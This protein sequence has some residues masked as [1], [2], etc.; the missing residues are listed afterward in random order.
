M[1][2]GL[3]LVDN[4]FYITQDPAGISSTIGYLNTYPANA[5]ASN[6]IMGTAANWAKLSPEV[7]RPA[8][9]FES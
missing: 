7:N 2:L 3:Q 9:A 4:D 6:F 1:T 8:V 5:T